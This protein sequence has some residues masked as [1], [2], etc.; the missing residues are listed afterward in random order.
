[1]GIKEDAI[2]TLAL[3]ASYLPENEPESQ[4]GH[5]SF[6][7]KH[8]Q[9]LTGFDLPQLHD[10]IELMEQSGYI[11]VERYLGTHP[12]DFGSVSLTARGRLEAEK[13]KK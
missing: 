12:Y 7:N 1:M 9:E 8:I 2:R 6:E 5:C 13:V 10:V 11:E 3:M 4:R